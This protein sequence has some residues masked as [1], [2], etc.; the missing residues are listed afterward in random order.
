MENLSSVYRF[1]FYC[2]LIISHTYSN[3]ELEK[4]KKFVFDQNNQ[5]HWENLNLNKNRTYLDVNGKYKGRNS[6]K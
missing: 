3:I 5:M 4:I 1:G 6:V 2:E